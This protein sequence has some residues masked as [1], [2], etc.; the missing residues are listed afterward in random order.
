MLNARKG[1]N[2]LAAALFVLFA[3]G[4][5]RL[6]LLHFSAG[7]VYTPYSTLR[8]DPVG[9]KALYQAL[10]SIPELRVERNL[11]PMSYASLMQAVGNREVTLFFLGSAASDPDHAPLDFVRAVERVAALGGRVVMTFAPTWE[12]LRA[13]YDESEFREERIERMR[14]R[15]MG[16]DEDDS[17]EDHDK[18]AEDSSNAPSQQAE[19]E[20]PEASAEKETSEPA[21]GDEKN[22][23]EDSGDK[24]SS[25]ESGSPYETLNAT[26]EIQE[27]WKVR[28]EFDPVERNPD[29]TMRKQ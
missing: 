25:D 5:I 16:Q 11:Q 4:A 9:S 10:G 17:A 6:Y 22:G 29:G 8:A 3:Y 1:M 15:R 14:K 28:L 24:D 20:E 19:A 23:E 21:E 18:E 13:V 27:R 7:D 2:I 26:V 12:D